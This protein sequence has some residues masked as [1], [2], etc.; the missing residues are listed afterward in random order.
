MSEDIVYTFAITS[1][2]YSTNHILSTPINLVQ[3]NFD[4]YLRLN[5][6]SFS[7]VSP[8][9]LTNK[10]LKVKNQTYII[11]PGLYDFEALKERSNIR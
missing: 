7:K 4:Y 1:N 6:I 3:T 9:V 8:N 2:T 5:T 11:K 10:T